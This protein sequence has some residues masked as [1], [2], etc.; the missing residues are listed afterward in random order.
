MK[1]QASYVRRLENLVL[2]RRPRGQR[3]QG[4]RRRARGGGPRYPPGLAR[5]KKDNQ[6]AAQNHHALL[7]QRPFVSPLPSGTAGFYD[8]EQGHIARYLVD[9]APSTGVAQSCFGVML[10]PN[11]GWAYTWVVA[12]STTA[13]APAF[14]YSAVFSPGYTTLTSTA[15]KQRAFAAAIRFAIPGLSITTITGEFAVGVT[16]YDNAV[17]V[18]SSDQ[19]FTLAAARGQVSKDQHEVRWYPGSFDSKYSTVTSTSFAAT[20]ADANDTNVLFLVVRGI[21]A[22]TTM[23]FQATSILEWTPKPN[24]G[25][26]PT[27]A[28]SAGTDHQH[29]VN[30]LHTADPGWHH[31]LKAAGE[32]TLSRAVS[33]GAGWLEKKAEKWI[34]STLEGLAALI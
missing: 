16:S 20:G 10:H 9:Y 32:R 27:M 1:I 28:S 15:Q 5:P 22:S 12:N 29:T 14:A 34:P 25:M 2:A 4:R 18:T 7:L 33:A 31:T 23:S 30:A 3:Q 8:G 17:A 6:A 19:L 26:T 13:I 24:T 11:T 21:P